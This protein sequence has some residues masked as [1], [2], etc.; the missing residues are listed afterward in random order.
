MF[1]AW[2]D[3][4]PSLSEIPST[5]E[6]VDEEVE[7]ENFAIEY[8]SSPIRHEKRTQ[9]EEDTSS[10][11]SSSSF[12]SSSSSSS[13]ELAVTALEIEKFLTKLRE[14]GPDDEA[15]DVLESAPQNEP[16]D[17]PPPFCPNDVVDDEQ[18]SNEVESSD[19]DDACSSSSSGSTSSSQSKAD[20]DYHPSS[21]SSD[22]DSVLLD[23]S[24]VSD[25]E[26]LEPAPKVAVK[27]QRRKKSVKTV[28]ASRPVKAARV[29][30]PSVYDKETKD[31][32]GLAG[33]RSGKFIHAEYERG[34]SLLVDS[35]GL[36]IKAPP[37]LV[38]K[39]IAA[40]LDKTVPIDQSFVLYDQRS[41]AGVFAVMLQTEMKREYP[42][43]K[44][45]RFFSNLSLKEAGAPRSITNHM[46]HSNLFTPDLRPSNS[47]HLTVQNNR[48]FENVPFF[49]SS[50][51]LGDF[52]KTVTH[53]FCTPPKGSTD[54]FRFDH[55]Q[56][57]FNMFESLPNVKT[58]WVY[59]CPVDLKEPPVFHFE[60]TRVVID[61]PMS[62]T[63]RNLYRFDKL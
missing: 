63:H 50:F 27:T 41:L 7:D 25:D 51:G 54:R 1:C 47:K 44:H 4:T 29:E 32:Y 23:L 20:A 62:A 52:L 11:P 18:I 26:E 19:G 42:I 2:I 17:F 21:S 53:V 37:H 45:G 30:V 58:L 16:D 28:P 22:D 57:A 33:F 12:S 35:A 3:T 36:E 9:P 8:T 60:H 49:P 46:F 40:Y 48:Y 5:L 10:S 13:S 31:D 55:L 14:E 15:Y 59:G 38:V 56:S 61:L 39:L 43:R 24:Q 34:V 6:L